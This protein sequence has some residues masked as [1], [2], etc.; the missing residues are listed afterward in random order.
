MITY[1]LAVQGPNNGTTILN[2]VKEISSSDFARL[3][4]AFAYATRAGAELFISTLKSNIRNW[5]SIKKRWI[6]SI[7]YGRTEPEALKILTSIPNSDVRIPFFEDVIR[8]N[9]VPLSCFHP[10]TLIL[11]NGNRFENGPSAFVIG[12][13][14]M[15]LSGLSLGY[16][17]AFV[18]SWKKKLSKEAKYQFASMLCEAYKLDPIFELATP[19]NS[20]LLKKYEKKRPRKNYYIEED[21][22]RIQAITDRASEVETSKAIALATARYLWVDIDYVVQNRGA[23]LPGNQVDLQRGTRIFFG[24]SPKRVAPNTPIG[25][26]RINYGNNSVVCH[27]RFGNNFMDKLNLPV[28]GSEG[29]PSYEN[30]TLLFERMHDGSFTLHL[31]TVKDVRIWKRTSKIQASYYTMQSGREYGC[32]S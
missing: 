3:T 6:I 20:T 29:P 25:I 23:G 26:V 28:P 2:L 22:P 17:N 5:D 9:F 4:G 7:D 24:Y 31:G 32:F 19:L 16:E 12:S 8:R 10:K 14:N 21:S 1:R 13:G 11:D 27:M 15:S 30:S 18:I